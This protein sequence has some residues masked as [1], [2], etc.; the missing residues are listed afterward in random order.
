MILVTVQCWDLAPSWL[1]QLAAN[2]VLAVPLTLNGVSRSIAFRRDRDLRVS[3]DAQMCGFVDLQGAGR[4]TEH[5]VALNGDQGMPVVVAFGQ[6]VPSLHLD[7]DVLAT[8]ATEVWSGVTFPHATSWG[9][10]HLY[11]ACYLDGFCRLSTRDGGRYP[12]VGSSGFP[13]ATAFGDS[14]AHLTIRPLDN[15]SD[16]V[17]FGARGF[18]PNGHKAATRMVEQVKAWD[19][20][21]RI[22]QPWFAYVPGAAGTIAATPATVAL[23]KVDGTVL[24]HWHPANTA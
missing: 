19:A 15:P 12:A 17:E 18:G 6:A 10:M 4:H 16:G 21:A 9:D 3:H 22:I 11:F 20:S 14:I 5:R 2:G 7:P 1:D 24:I 23:P 8:P 13:Q